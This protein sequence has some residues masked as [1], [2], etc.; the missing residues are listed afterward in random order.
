MSS[1]VLLAWGPLQPS[2]LELMASGCEERT[3]HLSRNAPWETF[4]VSGPGTSPG[5]GPDHQSL[6]GK[7]R[8]KD[9]FSESDICD[10]PF[11]H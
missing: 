11:L 5:G 10:L 8:T 2:R 1:G 7:I 6:T 4:T 3:A 9:T